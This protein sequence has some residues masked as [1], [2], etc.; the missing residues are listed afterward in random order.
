MNRR[1]LLAEDDEEM[2]RLLKDTLR[3]EGYEVI[4][5]SNGID[6][7]ENIEVFRR[8]V[9]S[10]RFFDVDLIISDVRMPW[11]SGLELLREFRV[12]DKVTPVILITAFGDEKTHAEAA[13][14]GACVMDKPFELDDFMETVR[15]ASPDHVPGARDNDRRADTFGPGGDQSL[16]G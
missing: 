13:R 14:L 12:L 5:A 3:R 15:A 4:G 10:G 16:G 2:S 1:V 7:L 9:L 8:Q 11:M 6:L